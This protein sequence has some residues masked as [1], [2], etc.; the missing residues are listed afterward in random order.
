[1]YPKFS[2]YKSTYKC[3]GYFLPCWLEIWDGF[4]CRIKKFISDPI[5]IWILKDS[6]S[7]NTNM[8][9]PKQCMNISVS[10]L[11]SLNGQILGELLPSLSILQSVSIC[12][13]SFS[14]KWNKAWQGWCVRWMS[15]WRFRFVHA[16]FTPIRMGQEGILKRMNYFVWYLLNQQLFL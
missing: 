16:S 10:I 7:E 13:P 6:F 1:M 4:Q 12:C 2:A 3:I 14:F 11:Y 8:H 9:E 15:M 5:G